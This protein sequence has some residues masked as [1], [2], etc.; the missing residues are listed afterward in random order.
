MFI[1]FGASQ[2]GTS[3]EVRCPPIDVHRSI[4]IEKSRNEIR[5]RI[6]DVLGLIERQH[7][8]DMALLTECASDD[9]PRAINI[10]LL[11]ECVLQ[12]RAEQALGAD[13]PCAGFFLNLRG[14]AAQAHQRS[15]ALDGFRSVVNQ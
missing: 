10:A 14:P 2:P 12:P 8:W 15:M 9:L 5:E 13:S 3:L 7:G 11:T 4:E 1:V 6:R